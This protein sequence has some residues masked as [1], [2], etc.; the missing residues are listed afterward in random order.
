MNTTSYVANTADGCVRATTVLQSTYN[1]TDYF[2]YC[3]PV[4]T[5]STNWD[6]LHATVNTPSVSMYLCSW[7][8]LIDP[9]ASICVCVHG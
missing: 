8:H 5:A 3:L 7:L 9:L 6:A 2:G 1:S 4:D